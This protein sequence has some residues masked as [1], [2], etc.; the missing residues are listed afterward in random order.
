MD[1]VAACR[2][3]AE[4]YCHRT[5]IDTTWELTTSCFP[6][7]LWCPTEMPLPM[8]PI[9]ELL[10]LAYVDPTGAQQQIDVSTLQTM[11]R[12]EPPFILPAWGTQWPSNRIQTNGVVL[13]YRAGYP[14]GSP[15]DANAV[16]KKVKQAIKMLT[17]HFY[18]NRE[19]VSTETRQIPSIMP[20]GFE[21]LLD[22]LKVYP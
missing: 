1:I 8:G 15:P 18:K 9:I 19:S 5:F 3:M 14:S 11:L 22:P 21:W 13:T 16:P 20:Q 17:G 10:S 4:D 2:E 12:S 6:A 7:S